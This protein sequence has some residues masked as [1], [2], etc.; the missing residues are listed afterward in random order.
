[1]VRMKMNC[2]VNDLEEDNT[3]DTVAVPLSPPC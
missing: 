1:M 3:R 2:I